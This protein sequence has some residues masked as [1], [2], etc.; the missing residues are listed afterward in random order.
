MPNE[1]YDDQSEWTRNGPSSDD[2]EVYLNLDN[3]ATIVYNREKLER[4]EEEMKSEVK[5][6]DIDIEECE[7]ILAEK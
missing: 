4:K 7:K 3:Q 1:N 5:K 2:I 6:K